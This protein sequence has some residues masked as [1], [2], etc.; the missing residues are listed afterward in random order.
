MKA[1]Q[2]SIERIAQKTHDRAL[3]AC[4][5]VDVLSAGLTPEFLQLVQEWIYEQILSVEAEQEKLT[6]RRRKPRFGVKR[7]ERIRSRATRNPALKA[8]WAEH[9]AL[10]DT[11]DVA[12]EQQRCMFRQI[13]DA[14]AWLVLGLDPRQIAPL[15]IE[16]RTH[17][18]PTELIGRSPLFMMHQLHS[19]GGCFGIV[20]DLTRCLST[21]D[22]T[23]VGRG[24]PGPPGNT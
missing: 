4:R 19:S 2:E 22:V 8:L 10:L 6:R 12:L 7:Q 23:I 16:G 21:G 20:N 15:F 24:S 5:A 17:H 18:L 3:F 13:G 9:N 11:R 1:L 14:C